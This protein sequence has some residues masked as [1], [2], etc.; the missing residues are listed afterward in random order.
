[1]L[2]TLLAAYMAIAAL[3]GITPY[4]YEYFFSGQVWQNSRP[5]AVR[6]R[7]C[8]QSLNASTHPIIFIQWAACHL[9]KY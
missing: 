7:Y 3:H 9:E 4:M 1:M 6:N 8:I 5:K 2:P